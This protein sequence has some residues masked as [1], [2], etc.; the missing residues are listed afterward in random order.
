MEGDRNYIYI[1]KSCNEEESKDNGEV[2]DMKVRKDIEG[3]NSK[4]IKTN[5]EEMNNYNILEGKDEIYRFSL[6]WSDIVSISLFNLGLGDCKVE[7]QGKKYFH[8]DDICDFIDEN[9]YVFS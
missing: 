4:I 5:I 1:C 8:K 7:I 9:W 2:N 3:K 6:S